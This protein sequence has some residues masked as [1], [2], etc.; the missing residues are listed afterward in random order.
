MVIVVS[1]D[2]SS[3]YEGLKPRQEASGTDRVILDR[4]V[5]E[6][7]RSAEAGRESERRQQDRRA[8]ALPAEQALMRVLGFMVLQPEPGAAI[9]SPQPIP[10]RKPGAVAGPGKEPVRRPRRGTAG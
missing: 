3:L 10:M 6:R 7:R 1:R 4:R 9:T 2:S 5:G 8:P